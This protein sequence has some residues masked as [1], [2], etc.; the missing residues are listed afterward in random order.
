MSEIELKS[1]SELEKALREGKQVVTCELGPP[2]SADADA[3]REKANDLKGLVHAINITDNQTA[4]VRMSSIAAGILT[5]Q[6]GLEPV[7][8]IT[9]R[10][11]NRLAIQ[12]DVLGAYALGIRNILCLS[13]D[14]QRFGNHPTAKNVFDMD[15]V[16]LIEMLRVMRDD[17]KFACGEVIRNTKKEP[18]VE[19]RIFIGASTNPFADPLPM[20]VLKLKKKVLAGAEFIQTQCVFDIPRMKEFMKMVCDQGIHEQ[21]FI[22]GGVVAVKSYR[23]LEYMRKNVPGMMIPEELVT[24]LKG[25]SD[26]KDESVQITAELCQQL[27]EIPGIVG[28]HVMTPEWEEIVPAIISRAGL[29]GGVAKAG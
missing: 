27:I 11:R 28:I 26:A 17:Q 22:L 9:C 13:G 10:D 23:G 29:D 14:H 2:K 21:T 8:Q 5:Q 3:V 4:I 24:R 7:I 18:I 20:H 19:P 16:Q 1:G 15:S 12:A 25:A 6:C